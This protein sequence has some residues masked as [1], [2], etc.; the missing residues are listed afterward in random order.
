MP[1]DDL[2]LEQAL[3]DAAPVVDTAGVLDQVADKRIR[4]GARTVCVAPS[5]PCSRSCW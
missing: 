2:R 3:H 5:R 4:G 1:T